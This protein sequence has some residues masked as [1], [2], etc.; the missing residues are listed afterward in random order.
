M[1]AELK[2]AII[3]LHIVTLIFRNAGVRRSTFSMPVLW[4]RR[5]SP[6]R[7]FWSIIPSRCNSRQVLLDGNFVSFAG[8]IPVEQSLHGSANR[9]ASNAQQLSHRPM[10]KPIAISQE[11]FNP[12]KQAQ[13]ERP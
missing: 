11:I 13:V 12:W 9:N 5:E 6:N 8:F 3:E 1:S 7:S 4:T 10:K 2:P